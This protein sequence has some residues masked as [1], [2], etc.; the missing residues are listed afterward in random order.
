VT[1]GKD[2]KGK[3]T[4]DSKAGDMS[5]LGYKGAEV[6][7]WWKPCDDLQIAAKY[8]RYKEKKGRSVWEAPGKADADSF[9]IASQYAL[10]GTQTSKCKVT[11]EGGPITYDFALKTAL[12][13]KS[14]ATFNVTLGD[15]KP[16]FGFVYTL[17]Q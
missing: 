11:Y 12:E 6:V 5:A 3:E 14:S 10:S 17:D 7:A 9:S 2:D 4:V 16:K 13:G 15:E 8:A 1:V